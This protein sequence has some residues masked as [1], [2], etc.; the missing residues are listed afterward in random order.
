MKPDATAGA[1]ATHWG[2]AL[3][4][5]W[6][7][8]AWRMTTAFMSI[9]SG[10]FILTRRPNSG[11]VILI[12]SLLITGVLGL[13]ALGLRE[14]LSDGAT[15]H[16]TLPHRDVLRDMLPWLGAIFAATYA[17]LYSRFASQWTYLAGLYNQMMAAAAQTPAA[18]DPERE[19]VLAAWRAGFIEDAEDLH[20]AT[21]PLY[22]GVILSLL[23]YPGVRETY[24]ANTA[25]GR[26]RLA[27]LEKRCRQA[28]AAEE[29]RRLASH[30]RGETSRSTVP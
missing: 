5:G 17:G 28:L 2:D 8:R 6:C 18:P 26:P 16:L 13:A 11:A 30:S 14:R 3:E 29:S 21:R 12:R 20:L 22:A 7:D 10:E 25:G 19:E 4:E 9:L 1:S 23:E 15:W 24:E 27:A